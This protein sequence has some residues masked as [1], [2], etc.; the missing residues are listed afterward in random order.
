MTNWNIT[1]RII[2]LKY[3]PYIRYFHDVPKDI[4]DYYNQYV[5][6]DNNVQPYLLNYIISEWLVYALRNGVYPAVYILTY[7][8]EQCGHLMLQ[9][10]ITDSIYAFYN[11]EYNIPIFG[12]QF[13][14]SFL[15][16]L[17]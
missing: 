2:P 9:D 15:L 11:S 1:D 13:V 7:G 3:E 6:I 16:K 12:K 17:K 4:I 10:H 5:F 8:W 14:P